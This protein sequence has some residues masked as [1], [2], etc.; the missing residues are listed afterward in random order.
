MKSV[1]NNR[2]FNHKVL[3]VCGIFSMFSLWLFQHPYLGLYHD[4]RMYAVQAL[5]HLYPNI[6]KNDVF[7]LYGSQDKFSIFSYFYAEVINLI[8]LDRAV[9]I[10]TLIGHFF[11]FFSAVFLL[12]R[13]S[14]GF[15]FWF[16]LLLITILPGFYGSERVFTYGEPYLTPRIFSEAFSLLSLGFAVSEYWILAIGVL[17]FAIMIHPLM[18]LPVVLILILYADGINKFLKKKPTRILPILVVISSLLLVEPFNRIFQDMDYQ[19]FNLSLQRSPFL[20]FIAWHN[21]DWISIFFSFSLLIICGLSAEG[22]QKKLFISI[23][24]ISIIGILLN[25]VGVTIF[26]NKLL[27]QVQTWRWLWLLKWMTYFSF[28]WFVSEYWSRSEIAKMT[29]IILVCAW[30]LGESASG[31]ICSLIALIL[32]GLHTHI[33]FEKN[34]VRVFWIGVA[35]LVIE[36]SVFLIL[37]IDIEIGI[38]NLTSN[39]QDKTILE[40]FFYTQKNLI[41]IV[42]FFIMNYFHN[43][44][45][46]K[47]IICY[48]LI[49]SSA[50]FLITLLQF[51]KSKHDSIP[52]CLSVSSEYDAFRKMIPLESSVFWENNNVAKVWFLLGRS[53][54]ISEAQTAGMVFNRQTAIE[55]L[56]RADVIKPLSLFDYSVAMVWGG[57]RFSWGQPEVNKSHLQS[58][59]KD[60][61]LGF[62]V[63]NKPIV[64]AADIAHINDKETDNSYYLYDCNGYR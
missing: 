56:R 30:I 54:Y 58:S 25:I 53:S 26:N 52:G 51:D 46:N 24:F 55:S 16:S 20:E 14:S 34:T 12:S 7:F 40:A 9:F 37:N 41:F 61:L 57:R 8:G 59:C 19:W 1:S 35:F 45:D 6:Y 48:S 60:P 49:S 33:K 32:W 18:A 29:I 36:S 39:Y 11:W 43:T 2:I 13:L 44:V 28:A 50:L 4:A 10:L 21:E 47:I 3:W 62:V 38:R 22:K 23:I 64:G 63:F 17:I 31:Y 5:F 15:V 42:V 27:L